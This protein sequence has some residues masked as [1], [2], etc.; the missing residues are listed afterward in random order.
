MT[1]SCSG[2]HSIVRSEQFWSE[3]RHPFPQQ[4]TRAGEEFQAPGYVVGLSAS[5]T[6][7]L[8]PWYHT[9][10]SS[11]APVTRLGTPR[12][13]EH[14]GTRPT[15]VDISDIHMLGDKRDRS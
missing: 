7:V 15:P 13:P 10:H 14:L 9:L 3:M 8:R 1:R 2:I 5:G 6:E 12:V 11:L 4:S